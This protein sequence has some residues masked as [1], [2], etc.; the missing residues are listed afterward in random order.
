M[1]HHQPDDAKYIVV[2]IISP[3]NKPAFIY[4]FPE[5]LA[6]IRLEFQD[7]EWERPDYATITKE[8]AARI[9]WF[10][11]KYYNLVDRIIVHCE[12]GISRS[13]GVVAALSLLFEGKNIVADNPNYSPNGLVFTKVL[14]AWKDWKEAEDD[15]TAFLIYNSSYSDRNKFNF[16]EDLPN[17]ELDSSIPSERNID[18]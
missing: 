11:E 8:Q 3:N 18:L 17:F 15:M 2:S 7:M 4:K 12:A 6:C 9:V 14:Q 10:V 1:E 5:L 16:T 13:A